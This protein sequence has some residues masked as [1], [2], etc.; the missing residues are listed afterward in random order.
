[1]YA[2]L[3]GND[4][5]VSHA[6]CGLMAA[7]DRLNDRYGRGTVQL[8]SAGVG[9]D[10]RS[11]TMKQQWRTPRYTTRWEELPQARAYRP[12]SLPGSCRREA[13]RRFSSFCSVSSALADPSP[14]WPSPGMGRGS[15]ALRAG[16]VAGGRFRF[17]C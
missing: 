9:G 15:C 11:W 7:L 2:L 14:L 3:D 6:G 4:F 8:A 13:T 12:S 5:H 16:F 10:A 1:M 17:T